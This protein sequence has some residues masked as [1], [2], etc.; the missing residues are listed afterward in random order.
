MARQAR[1][2][3]AHPLRVSALLSEGALRQQVGGPQVMRRQLDHL[4]RLATE[5]P[6][7]IEVRVLPFSAGAHPAFG[8]PFEILSFPSPRLPD[9]VWQEILTSIDI[10]DQSVRVTDYIVTF[11]ETRE[12]AL[13]SDESVDLIR[14]IAKEMT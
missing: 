12:L 4:V 2:D 6:A 3:G 8:G 9:L 11:A 14:R 1:F 7:Q 5:R 10:I 13:G